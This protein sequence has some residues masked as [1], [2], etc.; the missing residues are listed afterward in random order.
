MWAWKIVSDPTAGSVIGY[1]T[2]NS[3][4]VISVMGI[5][6]S[7]NNT[8]PIS[9]LI[10]TVHAGSGE[11]RNFFTVVVPAQSTFVFNSPDDPVITDIGAGADEVLEVVAETGGTYTLSIGLN[12][13]G[14]MASAP[15]WVV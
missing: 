10:R 8:A 13:R 7:H 6:A 2:T 11:I 14:T 4:F 1:M 9:L 5:Y 12:I 15:G 3:N